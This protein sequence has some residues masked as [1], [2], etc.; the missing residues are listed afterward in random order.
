ML[1]YCCTK[2]LC[3]GTIL[4]VVCTGSV[5][6]LGRVGSGEG[7]IGWGEGRIGSGEGR[8]DIEVLL[9]HPGGPFWAGRDEGAWGIP[10]G[11]ADADEA[12]FD[13]ALREFREETGFGAPGDAVSAVL[14][15]EIRKRSGKIV[16]AW[17]IE[18]DLD[19][20]AAVSNTFPLE[21]PP[22]SG[23]FIEVP[24]LDPQGLRSST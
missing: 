4:L 2:C 9:G 20:A 21:W 24:E 22:R 5:E 11:E 10:K 19:A 23:R 13:V 14:L 6:G 12:L 1:Y 17:A 16:T 18:G 3:E 15:G 8:I 7:R